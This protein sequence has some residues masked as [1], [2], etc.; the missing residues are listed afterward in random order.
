VSSVEPHGWET[1]LVAERDAMGHAMREG[2]CRLASGVVVVTNWIGG[3]PWG[4]TVSSCTSLSM[5][6]P[7]VLAC[8]VNGA[9]ST[10]AI[11]EQGCYGLNILGADQTDVAVRAAA[12][13][14]PKFI[15]DIVREESEMGSPVICNAVVA[16]HCELYNSVVVGDHTIFIGHVGDVS[17][18][19]ARSPLVFFNRQFYDLLEHLS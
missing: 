6:P 8:L 2:M 4:T 14:Q 11:L 16:I 10:R 17:F 9:V 15:D 19:Q 5:E 13:G 7:L 18:G 3:R 12:P 1:A